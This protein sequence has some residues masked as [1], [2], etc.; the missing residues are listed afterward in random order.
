MIY[1]K[2]LFM[3]ILGYTGLRKGNCIGRSHQMRGKPPQKN[4]GN[5]SFISVNQNTR[6]EGEEPQKHI[7]ISIDR[8]GLGSLSGQKN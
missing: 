2:Q 8:I 1:S 4:T 3:K 5:R 6:T 7:A